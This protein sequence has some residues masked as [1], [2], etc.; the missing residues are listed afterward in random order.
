MIKTYKNANGEIAILVSSGFGAGWSTWNQRALAYDKRVVEFFLSKKDDKNF[1][2]QLSNFTENPI[3]DETKQ[4][5]A[6][7]GYP[8]VYFGGFSSIHIEWIAPG[9][10]FKINEYDGF[11][12][13]EVGY[14]DFD[15][16]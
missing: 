10:P 5:F 1:L 6:S 8:G 15:V 9:T 4:Y 2:Y 13:L 7:I 3:K 12:S 16:L 11:E 14:N